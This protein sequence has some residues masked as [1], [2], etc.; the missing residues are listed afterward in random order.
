MASTNEQATKRD[1]KTLEETL[2]NKIKVQYE[3]KMRTEIGKKVTFNETD[4]FTN[5]LDELAG[6]LSDRVSQTKIMTEY[7]HLKGV[8]PL[9]AHAGTFITRFSKVMK[10]L[11]D[12]N[13]QYMTL[14]WTEKNRRVEDWKKIADERGEVTKTAVKGRQNRKTLDEVLGFAK[15]LSNSELYHLKTRLPPRGGSKHENIFIK[16]FKKTLVK[17]DKILE[18]TKLSVT[19]KEKKLQ[20]VINHFNKYVDNQVVKFKKMTEKSTKKTNKIIKRSINKLRKLRK[21]SKNTKK[22][23]TQPIKKKLTKKTPLKKKP[24]RKITTKKKTRKN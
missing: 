18:N 4:Q 15:D 5:S 24:L 9:F 23:V 10:E 20:K 17:F 11:R 14:A 16:N 22:K 3:E 21:L 2:I 19:D 13:I 1:L 8:A 12:V 7:P 6:K